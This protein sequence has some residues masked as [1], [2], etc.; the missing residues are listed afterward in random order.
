M[1]NKKCRHKTCFYSTV[2]VGCAYSTCIIKTNCYLVSCAAS[3]YMNYLYLT[4][5]DFIILVH[6]CSRKVWFGGFIPGVP[7]QLIFWLSQR[8]EPDTC[9][10][11]YTQQA[12]DLKKNNQFNGK[13]AYFVRW[14]SQGQ[15]LYTV[16]TCTPSRQQVSRKTGSFIW[17]DG[18]VYS[19]LS[20]REES[21]TS[22]S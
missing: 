21:N 19:G 6:I 16:Y 12:T 13:P 5:P 15:E 8:Q 11:L 20:Q 18:L 7:A 14:L 10:H 1:T 4:S 9:V 3:F 17:N 2:A 22:P